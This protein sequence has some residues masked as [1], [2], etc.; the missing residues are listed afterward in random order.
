MGSGLAGLPARLQSQQWRYRPHKNVNWKIL[1]CIKSRIRVS[2]NSGEDWAFRQAV[3]AL[4]CK[5]Q[6]RDYLSY[7]WISTTKK[8]ENAVRGPDSGLSAVQQTI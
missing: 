3:A 8:A 6:S 1:R 2:H 5:K 7:T 4:L